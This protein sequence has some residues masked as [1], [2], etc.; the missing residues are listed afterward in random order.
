MCAF[1][2]MYIV[3][4]FLFLNVGM[5]CFDVSVEDIKLEMQ[6]IAWHLDLSLLDK[7]DHPN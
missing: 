4:C 6:I 1:I 3:V 5:C 2:C 7:N